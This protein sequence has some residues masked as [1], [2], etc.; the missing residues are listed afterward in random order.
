MIDGCTPSGSNVVITVRRE[1]TGALATGGMN[2]S[3]M[4]QTTYALTNAFTNL[5]A[6]SLTG[7]SVF[8]ATG[9]RAQRG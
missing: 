5:P 6:T 4:L 2:G 8:D 1:V 7:A 9:H 3:L